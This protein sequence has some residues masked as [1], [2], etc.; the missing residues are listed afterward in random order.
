[1]QRQSPGVKHFHVMVDDGSRTKGAYSST[2]EG[3]LAEAAVENEIDRKRHASV[4]ACIEHCVRQSV[5]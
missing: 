5:P 2:L 4:V 3:A 1:M